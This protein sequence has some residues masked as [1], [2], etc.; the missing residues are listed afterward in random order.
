MCICK[1]SLL[2]ISLLQSEHFEMVFM[3]LGFWYQ[4]GIHFGCQLLM[5]LSLL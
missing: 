2:W 4:M 1:I 3:R 5:I